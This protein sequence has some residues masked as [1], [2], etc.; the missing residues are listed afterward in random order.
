MVLWV[1]CWN[2]WNVLPLGIFV[3]KHSWL[4]INSVQHMAARL[5]RSSF[6]LHVCRYEQTSRQPSWMNFERMRED[7]SRH[8]SKLMSNCWK[9]PISSTFLR[10]WTFATTSHWGRC[11]DLSFM[12]PAFQPRVKYLWI[13]IVYIAHAAHRAPWPQ[14]AKRRGSVKCSEFFMNLSF[15]TFTS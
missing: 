8:T 5:A 10:E 15:S 12:L 2:E 3:R 11:H 9:N 14:Q 6:Q 1:K 4:S 13:V 7:H